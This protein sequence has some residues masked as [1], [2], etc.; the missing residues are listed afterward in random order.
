M[1]IYLRWVFLVPAIL[2][3][4]IVLAFFA[5]YLRARFGWWREPV[6]GFVCAFGWVASAYLTAP[7]RKIPT[8]V[9]SFVAGVLLAWHFL[10]RAMYPESYGAL[11]YQ[12]T[13]LPFVA[14]LA[15]GVLSLLGCVLYALKSARDGA[16]VPRTSA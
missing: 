4:S 16:D 2:A 5:D 15:G 6:L 14:A 9:I 3:T 8:A 1:K 11:A 12:P 7:A 10:G 13:Y